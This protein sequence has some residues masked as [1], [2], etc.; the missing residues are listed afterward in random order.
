MVVLCQCCGC[1]GAV[2]CDGSVAVLWLCCGAVAALWSCCGC[3][4]GAVVCCGSG[5][6]SY[7]SALWSVGVLL[8]WFRELFECRHELFGCCFE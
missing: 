1:V 3:R 4:G 7:L 2:C 6:E 8:W 5:V